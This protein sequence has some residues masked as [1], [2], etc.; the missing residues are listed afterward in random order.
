M[1]PLS[2]STGDSPFRTLDRDGN[3]IPPTVRLSVVN[4]F[5]A[6]VTAAVGGLSLIATGFLVTDTWKENRT[7]NQTV[8]VTGSAKRTI[9]ADLGLLSGTV[10]TE[11]ESR[12]S[13]YADR[14]HAC[15]AEV[16]LRVDAQLPFGRARQPGRITEARGP[17][18]H[19][20]HTARA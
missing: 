17:K 5:I 16:G 2:R 11:S 3:R 7:L 10:A 12:V 8:S 20:S 13:S 14:V 6:P 15:C 9:K 19:H 18:L 1:E 4:R